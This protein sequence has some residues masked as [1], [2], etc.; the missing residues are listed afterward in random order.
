MYF[1]IQSEGEDDEYL[2]I[3]FNISKYCKIIIDYRPNEILYHFHFFD[4]TRY[5]L[6]VFTLYQNYKGGLTNFNFLL[7]PP[8]K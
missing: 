8:K 1:Y 6:M 2:N 7:N 3:S 4:N 5:T